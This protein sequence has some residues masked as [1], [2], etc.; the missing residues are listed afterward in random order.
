MA[1]TVTLQPEPIPLDVK[2]VLVGSPLLYYLLAQH[3]DDF[4]ELFERLFGEPLVESEFFRALRA[5]D[6]RIGLQQQLVGDAGKECGLHFWTDRS[7][8][9]S[10]SLYLK[11]HTFLPAWK[12]SS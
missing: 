10:R 2:I 1:S 9:G 11:R 12:A 7:E 4:A 6:R 5:R 3:D 8:P